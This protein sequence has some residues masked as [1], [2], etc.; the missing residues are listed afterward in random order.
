M[1][2]CIWLFIVKTEKSIKDS[3]EYIEYIE[4]DLGLNS[5]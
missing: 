2:Y 3:I 4:P 5:G 1:G